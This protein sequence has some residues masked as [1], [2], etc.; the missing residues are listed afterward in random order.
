M[1]TLSSARRL[2]VLLGPIAILGVLLLIPASAGAL[3]VGNFGEQQRATPNQKALEAGG[4]LQYHGGPVL[5]SSDAYVVYWDPIGNYRGDWERLIDRYFKDVGEE[6]ENLGDV[7]ALDTQY[8]DSEG[9]A[10]NKTTFRGAY[11]D[12]DPYPT[13]GNCTEPSEEQPGLTAHV[14]LTDSQIQ[15]ELQHLI[16]SVDPPLPGA[17]GTPVYYVLT[18]PG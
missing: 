10:S 15:T 11:K 6:S 1:A 17:S 7:F 16:S 12:E 5:H 8:S 3:I 13:S 2:A 14:C 9:R 4:P 18:P